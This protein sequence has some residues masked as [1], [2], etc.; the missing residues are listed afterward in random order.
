MNAMKATVNAMTL[1][2]QESN[3][4]TKMLTLDQVTD[5]VLAEMGISTSHM[6]PKMRNRLKKNLSKINWADDLDGGSDDEDAS[7]Y[8]DSSDSE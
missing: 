1:A 8:E 6:T 2:P 5:D 4:S 3:S 7:D